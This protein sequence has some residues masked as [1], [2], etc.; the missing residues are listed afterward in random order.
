M[1]KQA[2]TIQFKTKTKIY[3]LDDKEVQ[4]IPLKKTITKHDCIKVFDHNCSNY[5]FFTRMLNTEYSDFLKNLRQQ[6]K[7]G[8]WGLQNGTVSYYIDPMQ[9][10]AEFTIKKG[11]LN[12]V[13]FVLMV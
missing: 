5:D 11:F 10:S 9:I 13:S 8:S 3:I 4:E 1:T 12:I 7:I 2:I 6:N